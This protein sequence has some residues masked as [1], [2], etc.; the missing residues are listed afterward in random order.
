MVN[1]RNKNRSIAFSKALDFKLTYKEE[2]QSVEGTFSNLIVP[3]LFCCEFEYLKDKIELLSVIPLPEPFTA[4]LKQTSE[5]IRKI[6]NNEPE[7]HVAGIQT[8][9]A[10]STQRIGDNTYLPNALETVPVQLRTELSLIHHQTL[11]LISIEPDKEFKIPAVYETDSWKKLSH[12]RIKKQFTPNLILFLSGNA[13]IPLNYLKVK[14]Q[15][16]QSI[17]FDFK[18]RF[19]EV[20]IPSSYPR[21]G[22]TIGRS[23]RIPK[24]KTFKCFRGK[25]GV[26]EWELR[27]GDSY[28]VQL[29]VKNTGKERASKICTFALALGVLTP[30]KT[31]KLTK[32]TLKLSEKL[33]LTGSVQKKISYFEDQ[34][35]PGAVFSVDLPVSLSPE[36]FAGGWVPKK[37]DDINGFVITNPSETTYPDYS[38]F[39]LG[40]NYI[41]SP[42]NQ[43]IS[44]RQREQ[45]I[46]TG[47]AH[48]ILDKQFGFPPLCSYNIANN[49]K[50][51]NNR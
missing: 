37:A 39:G 38:I 27:N 14:N 28:E 30:F 40:V 24:L 10:Q 25:A 1:R 9:G 4:L 29:I 13:H 33:K 36:Q 2:V 26:I 51:G 45:P 12:Y 19:T 23:R 49:S 47:L 15:F 44:T 34:K 3:A 41:I 46:P 35:A 22:A 7:F 31:V 42:E 48:L 32:S 21:F 18:E 11:C 20:T 17:D 5:E 6:E 16:G 8:G 50:E 43:S